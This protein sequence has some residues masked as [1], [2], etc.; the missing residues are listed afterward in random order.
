MSSHQIAAFPFHNHGDFDIG[1]PAD[2]P[3]L[4]R[5]LDY[6]PH[7]SGRQVGQRSVRGFQPKFD[8]RETKEA[9]ELD[10]EL[11]GIDQK[12]ISIEF[13]DPTTLVVKGRV[14][15]EYSGPGDAP[16]QGRITG[17]V[18]DQHHQS[19]KATVEDETSEGQQ[20]QQMTQTDQKDQKQS[21]NKPR[22]WI[23]ERSVG[24][25]SRAFSFPTRV[26]QDNVK[27]SLKNGILS[28]IIPKA[29]T[30]QAKKISIQ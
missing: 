1:F 29:A 2:V 23:T 30:H 10:G 25:F 13:I 14:E 19:H 17:D 7:R 28:I 15:R 27:A 5:L 21:Q 24:E 9:F 3:A 8:L 4:L 12:D 11:P 6:E 26:D 18:S 16:Q 22:F 20:Q